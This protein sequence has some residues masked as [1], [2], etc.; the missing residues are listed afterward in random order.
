MITS[1]Y[2]TQ[3]CFIRHKQAFE[4]HSLHVHVYT[5]FFCKTDYNNIINNN[6]IIN[7]NKKILKN[8]SLRTLATNL[9]TAEHQNTSLSSFFE[10]I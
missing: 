2:S 9:R 5:I 10:L 1:Y 7:D 4:G 8:I 3:S 6:N